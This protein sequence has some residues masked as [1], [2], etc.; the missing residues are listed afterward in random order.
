MVGD[1]GTRTRPFGVTHTATG[2][3]VPLIAG[4]AWDDPLEGSHPTLFMVRDPGKFLGS[5]T[6][7]PHTA[8]LEEEK[9]LSGTPVWHYRLGCQG[10]GRKRG[11][12]TVIG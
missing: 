3:L 4:V 11:I 5:F 6:R 9:E 2:L 8:F 7:Q 1:K 12:C 10:S